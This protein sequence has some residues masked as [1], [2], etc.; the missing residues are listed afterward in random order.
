[1]IGSTKLKVRLVIAVIDFETPIPPKPTIRFFPTRPQGTPS[2]V[3]TKQTRC[4]MI[5]INSSEFPQP[6]K[7]KFFISFDFPLYSKSNS[8]VTT[9][10]ITA[11]TAL[12]SHVLVEKHFEISIDH[13]C[14][15]HWNRESPKWQKL[16]RSLQI[17]D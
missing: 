5:L 7:P 8:A 1:M 12:I 14:F 9:G 13:F 15:M 4:S 16:Q 3:K 17:L 2:D 6:K 11:I 10:W